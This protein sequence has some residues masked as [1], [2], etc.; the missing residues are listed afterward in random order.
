MLV[1]T[2][3]AVFKAQY[4]FEEG[5][6]GMYFV[7]P[8]PGW[9]SWLGTMQTI[10]QEVMGSSLHS[11]THIQ[12]SLKIYAAFALKYLQIVRL[13]LWLGRSCKMAILSHFQTL[14]KSAASSS[15]LS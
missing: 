14:N 5:G 9:F 2:Q 8:P 1:I 3:N 10:V 13:S 4:V 7:K 6:V 11:Q 15:V 12:G